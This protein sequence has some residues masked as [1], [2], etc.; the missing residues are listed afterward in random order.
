MN[1]ELLNVESVRIFEIGTV[2]NKS[3]EVSDVIEHFSLTL[4]VRTKKQSVV[5]KDDDLLKKAQVKL[6]EALG[7]SLGAEITD[8]VLE[9]SISDLISKLPNITAY[10]GV[11]IQ[12]E[13][14]YKP[15]SQYP[16]ISRD[17]ALWVPENISSDIVRQ[18]ITDSAG[19]LLIQISL[20]DEFKKDE[21]VSYAY[22]LIFQ[23]MGRTLTDDEIGQAMNDVSKSLEKEGFELR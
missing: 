22:R 12:D 14:V 13:V 7:V 3:E 6:E 21:K 18:N 2:F 8:G 9:C 4:G 19:E 10:E 16:Y 11:D 17:I 5:A 1:I 20:F 15:Y 23:S